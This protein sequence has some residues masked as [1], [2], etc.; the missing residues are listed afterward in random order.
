VTNRILQGEYGAPAISAGDV[1]DL[2]LLARKLKQPAKDDGVSKY[3]AAQLAPAT[4]NLLSNY[5]G[6]GDV[7]LREALAA[8]L[9]R[10]IQGG[11]LYEAQRFTNVTL[12]ARAARLLE[13]NP[14]LRVIFTSGYSANIA[15]RELVLQKGQDFLQK[16]CPI[17]QILETVRRCLD[18]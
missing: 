14:Q 8:D 9:N 17:D 18:S 16:P 13:R 10:V 15:G 3:L 1:V 2:P 12:S 7:E 11:R 6:K 5:T 4:L